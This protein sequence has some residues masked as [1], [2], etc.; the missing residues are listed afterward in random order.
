MKNENESELREKMEAGAAKW[1][2][3]QNGEWCTLKKG[4]RLYPGDEIVVE[5]TDGTV[6]NVIVENYIY[7][8]DLGAHYRAEDGVR[9]DRAKDVHLISIDMIRRNAEFMGPDGEVYKTTL[10]K[11][12]CPEFL[13]R[14]KPCKHIYKLRDEVI[15]THPAVT[16]RPRKKRWPVLAG[17][18]V[19]IWV[20]GMT[21]ASGNASQ[22]QP[23][24]SPVLAAEIEHETEAEPEGFEVTKET[25]EFQVR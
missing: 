11:C 17:A 4:D 16:A 15:I 24:Q 18:L 25:L 1:T 6:K 21:L 23:M 5:K 9:A 2:R 22:P 13:E 8:D 20:A 3:G 19:F 12:S 7:E 14:K 10:T